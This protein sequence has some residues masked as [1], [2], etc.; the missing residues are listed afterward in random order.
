MFGALGRLVSRRPWYVIAA[1]LVA[2]VLVVMFHP[3]VEATTDQADF[4]PDSYDSIK[5][6]TLMADAFPDQTDSGATVVFDRTDG[7]KLAETDVAKIGEIMQGLDLPK[8]FTSA[9]EPLLS[10]TSEVAISNLALAEGVTG[11]DEKE[12][13]QVKDLRDELKKATDGTGLRAQTTGSLPQSYDQIQSSGNAEAIVGLAT[14]VLIVLLL[15]IIFRSVLITLLP[16]VAVIAFMTPMANGLIDI[17]AKVF[18]LQKDPSTTVIL[19]VVLFG[20]GTD[21]VLFFVFRYRERLREGEE[22]RAAVAHAIERAGEAIASAGGAVVAAFMALLLST[23]GMFRSIGPSLAIAVAVS[24]VAALTLI[25]AF[26]TVVGRAFFWPSKKWRIASKGARF[27]KIGNAVG[28]S[29]VRYALVSG[30][31]L[32]VLSIFALSFTPTFD[33]GSSSSAKNIESAKA[34]KTLEE[35]GFSAGATQ[36]A[37][38]VLHSDEALDPATF[39]AFKAALAD[40]KGVSD[41]ADPIPAPDGRTAIFMTT[42]EHDPS[43][44]DALDDVREGLRPAAEKAA[45]DGTTPYVGGLTAIFVDFQAAMNRDYKVVFPVAAA[46]ILIILAL[47]LRSL[48]APWYLMV[49]VGL[50]FAATLGATTIV[51]QLIGGADGLIFILPIYI[52]LFVVALGTD[53]NILM[54]ARLREEAREGLTPREA[55]AKAIHHGGPTIAAAGLIL[56][57]TFASLMLAGNSFMTSMGF[58]IAFGICVAAFVMAMFFTPA[59]TALI[60]HAA[61]WPGHGDE[62]RDEEPERELVPTP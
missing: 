50:G 37:P 38:V 55:A 17:A 54:V 40:A 57:G 7:A 36:P 35:G 41:V 43:S 3:K 15:S 19:I 59:L 56:A 16:L 47:L 29:P 42:L 58:A 49:S 60:G 52:Y 46:I 8:V 4:L 2:T 28:R 13:D 26:A 11:Q 6:A 39:P 33:I 12:L 34:S 24:V 51:F 1:W 14:V 48:V 45:P 21:Y 23:L 9:G 30:G 5:A 18:G 32:L 25:P 10:P 27:E 62:K 20:V 22:H 53:Y 31:A 44:D 61:W